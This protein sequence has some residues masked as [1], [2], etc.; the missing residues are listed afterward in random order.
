[1]THPHLRTPAGRPRARA[2]GIPFQGEAGPLN[3]ITDVPGLE[4]GY[5]TRVEGEA[6]RTGVTAIHPRGR[7]DAAT[8][9]AA[10]FHCQN[11]NG[12]M[13]GVSWVGESGTFAGPVAITS[14]HAVGTVHR[15]VVDWT[16][17]RHPALAQAWLL[18]VVGE[19]WDGYLNDPARGDVAAAMAVSV[20]G[21]TG[22]VCYGFKGGSGTASRRVPFAGRQW[23]V[24]VF[25]QANFGR[26]RELT[27][28]GARLGERLA[29]DDPA[30]ARADAPPGSG[31][32]IVVIATDAPLLPHQLATLARR[33]PLGLARTGTTG[34]HYSG[35]LV[36]ALS[37]ANAGA[38]A[39]YGLRAAGSTEALASLAFVPWRFID[40]FCEAVVQGVEEAVVN[41]LVANEAMT[42][43]D[44]HRVP[45]LPPARAMD[46]AGW[47]APGESERSATR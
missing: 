38:L 16:L 7:G 2:L 3:A 19:T 27:I 10:A 11:G 40:P 34:S 21:G 29:D 6:V 32:V 22:M 20:G 42:G 1:M 15:A 4:V 37:T 43:R 35:D 14:T 25:V 45:A 33:A 24:G 39:P 30:D 18:P 13:T 47:I 5:A 9:V 12:E 44:G 23:S 26:R 17:A 36:L 46:L 31:S 41:S 28:A 8:P